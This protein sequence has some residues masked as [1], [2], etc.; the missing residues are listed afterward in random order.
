MKTVPAGKFKA[1][2]LA[3]LDEV[4]QTHETVVVTKYGKPVAQVIP[5]VADRAS[6]QNSLKGTVVYEAD[7]VGPVDV[8]W[9]T[10]L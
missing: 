1:K 7:I 3:M 10:K 4:A 9:E 2:C 6:E 8:E 5:Y